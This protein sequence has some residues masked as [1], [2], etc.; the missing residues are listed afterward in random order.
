MPATVKPRG[1]IAHAEALIAAA[2]LTA[3]TAAFGLW[4]L[5]DGWLRQWVG[6]EVA[7]S[8]AA[9]AAPADPLAHPLQVMVS[10]RQRVLANIDTA[11]LAS[12]PPAPP[13]LVA[14]GAVAADETTRARV[15]AWAEGRIERLWVREVGAVIAPGSR[16]AT[17]YSPPLVE[18]Q[19]VLLAA[20]ARP[21]SAASPL[22]D[23]ARRRL[24]LLGMS[25]AAIE[26][27]VREGVASPLVDV[28]SQVGG[29]VVEVMARQGEAVME[30]E[31]LLEVIDL[32]RVWV[33]VEVFERDLRRV[34][35]GDSAKV[36]PQGARGRAAPRLGTVSRIE[37]GID[38]MRRTARARVALANLDD[39]APDGAGPALR[40]GQAVEVALHPA[41]QTPTPDPTP[42]TP[43]PPRAL[44]PHR[45]VVLSAA[46]PRAWVEVQPNVFEVRL[47]TLGARHPQG[48]EVEGGL[49]PDAQVVV[50][51]LF[52]V[53]SQAAL[54][55]PVAFQKLI[56]GRHPLHR[57]GGTIT[58]PGALVGDATICPVMK[59]TFVVKE[60]SPSVDYRGERIYFCCGGCDKKFIADPAR[61]LSNMEAP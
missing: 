16:V 39:P 44:I 23:E 13:P 17:V 5:R 61:Y 12:A 14:L 46:Q 25:R 6:L 55:Q 53:D 52:L 8:D 57:P 9:P 50:S 31:M 33:E 56:E 7:A 10:D 15:T 58:Q 27:L 40:L 37:P 20:Q 48:F 38:P 19:A 11:P 3:A 30:G 2:L 41:P 1:L 43:K 21:N 45:A 36:W 49:E 26:R 54:E 60:T 29:V 32:S 35:V 34:Q 22:A 47:L 24:A 59:N 51:G 28:T 42:A 18:A 4:L